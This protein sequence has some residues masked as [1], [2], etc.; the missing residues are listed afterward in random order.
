MSNI[1]DAAAQLF[2][3]RHRQTHFQATVVDTSG[4]TIQVQRDG[5]ATPEGVFY[6]AYSGV[7][8]AVSPGDRVGVVDFTGDGAYVVTGKIVNS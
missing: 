1:L 3:R 5:Q 6:A 2:A 4:G 7:A 8:A